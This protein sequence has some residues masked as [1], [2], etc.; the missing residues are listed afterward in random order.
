MARLL[1]AMLAC[2]TA[3][4]CLS[5]AQPPGGKGG[6]GP[7]GPPRFELGKVLPPHVREEL[8]LT[9]A[10]EKQIDELEREVKKRLEKILTAAQQKKVETIGPPRGP[11]GPGDR[12]GKDKR[13]EKD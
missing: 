5:T 8:D 9:P 10:Q 13:K 3:C 1:L 11:G 12:D 7:G 4:V 6:K 2:A